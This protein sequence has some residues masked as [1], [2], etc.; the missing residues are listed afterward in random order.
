MEGFSHRD[1]AVVRQITL[2]SLG[3][4]YPPSLF[5][6]IQGWWSEGFIVVK[7]EGE[8]VA[9]V[10]GVVSAPR[11]ARVLMLAVRE[12]YRN[13]RIGRALMEEFTKR[14]LARGI[15]S[16]ELEVR[17]SNTGAI[18]FYKRLGYS[19]RYLL[20]QFYTD[21]EDGFKMWRDLR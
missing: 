4:E 17:K 1:V 5:L 14:C 6:D 19:I 8:I 21:K 12:G 15:S 11:Q 20:P 7:K 9:F 16:I 3:E 10:A 2:E 13:Q 18:R